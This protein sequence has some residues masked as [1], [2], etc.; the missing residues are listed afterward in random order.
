MEHLFTK[1]VQMFLQVTYWDY[2][3]ANNESGTGLFICFDGPT[4]NLSE[5]QAVDHEIS[6]MKSQGSLISCEDK[7]KSD[8]ATRIVEDPEI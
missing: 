5:T 7:A 8:S 3:V 4:S 6:G 1:I 2:G